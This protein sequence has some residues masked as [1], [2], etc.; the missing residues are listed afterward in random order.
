MVTVRTKQDNVYKASDK[1]SVKIL[2]LIRTSV[3]F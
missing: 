3:L 2:P 1:Q